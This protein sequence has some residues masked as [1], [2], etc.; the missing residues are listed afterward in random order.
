MF[1]DMTREIK[2]IVVGNGTVGKTTMLKQFAMGEQTDQYKKTVG[3]DFFEKEITVSSTGDDAKLLLWD[4]AGQEMFK[5]LTQRY[6][7]GAGAVVYAF[8]TDN[9]DSFDDL[10]KWMSKV[11]EVCGKITCVLV[12]NKIDLIDKAAVDPA[13]VEAFAKKHQIK[14]YRTSALKNVLID[15]V[16]DYLAEQFIAKGEDGHQAVN[17][18][19]GKTQDPDEDKEKDETTGEVK[20]D[21]TV[22]L[23]PSRKRTGGKKKKFC[24]IL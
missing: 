7:K 16:F 13:E 17:T 15:D 19:E 9:R 10:E 6:Y 11:E 12:Q 20:A 14:L 4:T 2:I 21:G 5:S 24:T 23:G 3:T 22:K 8:A 1:E 18:M